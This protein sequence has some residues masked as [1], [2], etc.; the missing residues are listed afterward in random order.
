MYSAVCCKIAACK[1][2][3]GC[4]VI[5]SYVNNYRFEP[6]IEPY[7]DYNKNGKSSCHY[8]LFRIALYFFKVL[9]LQKSFYS[10]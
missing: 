10:S 6:K 3:K 1:N 7:D 5:T 8:C 9:S 4:E 2:T